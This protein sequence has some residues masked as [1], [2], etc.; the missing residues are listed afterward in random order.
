MSNF[1][2]NLTRV[3]FRSFN[4]LAA[5]AFT[6]FIGPFFGYRDLPT[7]DMGKPGANNPDLPKNDEPR[8]PFFK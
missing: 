3:L 8:Y 1:L 4:I 2:L 6:M 5:N 7:F